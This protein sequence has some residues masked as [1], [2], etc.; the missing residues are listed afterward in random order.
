MGVI[1][2]K[3]R[4]AID[5]R[6]MYKERIH[7]RITFGIVLVVATLF[8]G[9]RVSAHTT[10]AYW[11]TPVDGYAIDI[12]YDPAVITAGQYTRFDFNL[13]VGATTSAE[14]ADFSQVWV[15]ILHDKDTLLATGIFHQSIGPTTLLYT[16][17]EAGA[18]LLD[19][20]FRDADGNEIAAASFPIQTEDSSGGAPVSEY[21]IA[22]AALLIGAALGVFVVLLRQRKN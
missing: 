12:G 1:V 3:Y 6:I 18:Y 20:S 14:I 7:M 9:T 13:W 22:A 8:F 10:G 4:R 5:A 19:V 17:P 16:F 11:E 15:R 21:G 2:R